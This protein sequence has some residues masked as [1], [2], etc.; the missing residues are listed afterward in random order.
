[1]G[2]YLL[3]HFMCWLVLL[4]SAITQSTPPEP[5]LEK[6]GSNPDTF[7][8]RALENVSQ[9]LNTFNCTAIAEILG[10]FTPPMSGRISRKLEGFPK[11]VAT[12][13]LK[14]I[15]FAAKTFCNA[16]DTDHKVDAVSY[17]VGVYIAGGNNNVHINNNCKP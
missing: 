11:K 3:L 15:I 16:D 4:N 2:V 10:A 8:D 17:E 5:A 13:T 9:Y 1:M 6:G 7:E 14:A 12:V